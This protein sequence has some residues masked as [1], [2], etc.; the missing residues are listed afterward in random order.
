MWQGTSVLL[1]HCISVSHTAHNSMWGDL[2]AQ[3]VVS[4]MSYPILRVVQIQINQRNL[5]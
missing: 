1:S 2:A 3:H 4:R 5:K